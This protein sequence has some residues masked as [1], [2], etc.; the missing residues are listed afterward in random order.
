VTT[1]VC[2]SLYEY[3]RRIRLERPSAVCAIS[4]YG[5]FSC[6]FAFLVDLDVDVLHKQYIIAAVIMLHILL[7]TYCSTR[8]SCIFVKYISHLIVFKIKAGAL[9]GFI[10]CSYT[11]TG[12]S[13]NYIK[14]FGKTFSFS[15]CGCTALWTLAAL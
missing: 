11:C 12:H 8:S 6:D 2:L 1:S 7:A 5:F 10:F 14:T 13:T 4:I 15:L 3:Y 9:V